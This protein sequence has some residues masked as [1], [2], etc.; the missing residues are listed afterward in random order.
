LADAAL[1]LQAIAH[2]LGQAVKASVAGDEVRL[3]ATSSG[4]AWRLEIRN[5]NR[6][7]VSEEMRACLE[8][9]RTV[10]FHETLRSG[11]DTMALLIGRDVV[12]RHGGR[13]EA[14]P[15]GAF[16]LT[17]PANAQPSGR[18]VVLVAD[19]DPAMRD[20]IRAM[21]DARPY[22]VHAH[23]DASALLAEALHAPPALVIVEHEQAAGVLE[24]LRA[25]PNTADVP[26]LL[27]GHVLAQPS[28]PDAIMGVG[29]LAKPFRKA[30]LLAAVGQALGAPSAHQAVLSSNPC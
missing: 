5:V 30:A 14:V 16:S 18:A 22:D 17:L 11:I 10:A 12:E 2:L 23:A 28:A 1:M 26:I 9:P 19:R 3:T 29:R 27:L 20:V 7:I 24:A 8:A 13:L 21:L 4:A 25:E 15:G 6:G